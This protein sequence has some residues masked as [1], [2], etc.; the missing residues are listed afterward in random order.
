M[1]KPSDFSGLQGDDGSESVRDATLTK[2]GGLEN[3]RFTV[4][5]DRSV[6]QPRWCYTTCKNDFIKA[7]LSKPAMASRREAD[8]ALIDLAH[9]LPIPVIYTRVES[10]PAMAFPVERAPYLAARD[11]LIASKARQGP[12]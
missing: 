8:Q 12:N 2:P 4:A 10:D 1:R 3:E 7:S 6:K 11:R 5:A 9:S